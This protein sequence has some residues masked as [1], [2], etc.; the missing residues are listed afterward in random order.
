MRSVRRVLRS[1]DGAGSGGP[2]ALGVVFLAAAP[3]VI[4]SVAVRA[5]LLQAQIRL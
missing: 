4:A 3:V 5:R 1:S 2:G